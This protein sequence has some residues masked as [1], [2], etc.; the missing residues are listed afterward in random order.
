M[1]GWASADAGDVSSSMS[2]DGIWRL[3][4]IACAIGVAIQGGFSSLSDPDLPTHLALGEWIIRH[5]GVPHTEPFAW[6]RAGAPFYSYSWLAQVSMF[7]LLRAWGPLGLH[8]LAAVACAGVT[9]A[10]AA[11]AR[12]LG[13]RWSGSV[14][15]AV[16][17]SMIALESTPFLRPQLFLHFLVPLTWVAVDRL[18]RSPGTDWKSLAAI[19]GLNAIAANTHISFPVMAA[20]L[21]LLL[22]DDGVG[23]SGHLIPGGL[24]V[25]A[26]WL[27]SPYALEWTDVFRLNFASNVLTRPPALTG[28]LTPGF[29]IAPLYG[30]ALGALPL[31]AMS[32]YRSDRERLL[33]GAMWLAGLILF[34][35]MF[36]GLGPWWWCATPMVIAVIGRLP[37]ASGA[38]VRKVFASLLILFTFSLAISNLRLY[39]VLRP[40]EGDTITRTLPS[41]RASAAE[42][43]A[44]WLIQRLPS[45]ARGRLLT[46]FHYGSY[47]EWRVSSLSVSIDGRTIFPDSAA[48]PDA[49][50]K[51]GIR[52]FGPWRSADLAIVPVTYPVAALLDTDT[53]WTKIGV[54]RS[55]PWAPDVPQ[56]GLWVRNAWWRS[57]GLLSVERPVDGILR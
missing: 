47:L 17:S 43:A 19:L 53:S 46:V 25:A 8:L 49:V 21:V 51:D 3:T 24:A 33:Y 29:L 40:H 57:K 2:S 28:E 37:R 15:F 6:T 38:E 32:D 18:R 13:L 42:P 54:A 23:V 12:A 22:T 36:K 30:V 1:I 45:T 34:A 55:E 11:A 9:L 48:L 26:G 52:H 56:A 31:A 16:A 50:T 41:V 35:R 10:S 7:A 44:R 39:P 5:R 20:A 27:L 14:V 4:L